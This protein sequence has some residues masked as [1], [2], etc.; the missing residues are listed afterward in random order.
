MSKLEIKRNAVY[1]AF[2]MFEVEREQVLFEYPNKDFE[3]ATTRKLVVEAMNMDISQ[4]HQ[5]ILNELCSSQFSK[6]SRTPVEYAMNLIYGWLIEDAVYIWLIQKGFT[7]EK[8]GA[9]KDREFLSARKIS[10]G[11]DLSINGRP[12]DIFCDMDGYWAKNDSMDIRMSKYNKLKDNGLIIGVSP[13]NGQVTGI[14]LKNESDLEIRNNP[15]W[16]GREVATLK[17]MSSKL[18][19]VK[20]LDS[21]LKKVL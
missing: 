19:S 21:N 20:D 3:K 14:D 1:Q 17:N 9:D 12:T 13:K 16:G 15:L 7:V 8:T 5:D 10:A 6:E 4:S 18:F 11:E 2:E